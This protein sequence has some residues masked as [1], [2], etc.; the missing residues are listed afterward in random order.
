[1]KQ[2]AGAEGGGEVAKGLGGPRDAIQAMNQLRIIGIGCVR[3]CH[4][5]LLQ[6]EG[7]AKSRS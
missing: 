6:D 3:S 7:A 1:M 4:M 2:A 5:S